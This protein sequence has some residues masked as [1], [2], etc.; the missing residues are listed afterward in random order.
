MKIMSAMIFSR[1]CTFPSI[2]SIYTN[3]FY[4]FDKFIERMDDLLECE[5][6]KFNSSD[7]E[8]ICLGYMACLNV[9]I[10]YDDDVQ[11]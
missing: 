10:N 6:R 7:M 3:I 2:V 11:C 8:C 4:N 1:V 5:G 9:D